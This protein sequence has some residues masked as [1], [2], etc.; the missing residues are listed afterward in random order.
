MKKFFA[1]IALLV[2]V[3]VG[4]TKA[5]YSVVDE[6][7]MVSLNASGELAI[8]SSTLSK[9]S[10]TS[11]R[12]L[13]GVQIYKVDKNDNKSQYCYGLFDDIS[14]AS[15]SM[16]TSETYEIEVSYIPGGKD[17]VKL[18]EGTEAYG[19]WEIPFNQ[20]NWEKIALNE[21]T[22]NTTGKIFN[23]NHGQV[24]SSGQE[25]TYGVHRS[26]ISY[27]YAVV[28]NYK[29]TE[30]NTTLDL[31]LL[32]Y[33]FGMEFKFKSADYADYTSILVQV[34]PEYSAGHESFTVTVNQEQEYSTV[35]ISPMLMFIC[36]N[37]DCVKVSIGTS[38]KPTLFYYG[39]IDVER[40]KM[41]H[42]TVTPPDDSVNSGLNVT[43]ESS[44]MTNENKT[45]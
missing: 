29:P 23:L 36:T 41:Y 7:V 34:D 43:K 25:R 27:Y 12:D 38:E 3:V 5:S 45:L 20:S 16:R 33:N 42:I 9:A 39:D 26:G 8:T 40:N 21:I 22:Y 11:S 24:V 32:R 2:L 6:T 10:A 1:Q 14:L 31:N 37:T 44:E 17:I 28:E 18:I 4:C 30:D 19:S 13:Y 15:V 35:T